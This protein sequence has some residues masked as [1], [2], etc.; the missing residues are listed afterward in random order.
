MIDII[1]YALGYSILPAVWPIYFLSSKNKKT[2]KLIFAWI[3]WLFVS[4]AGPSV[5]GKFSTHEIISFGIVFVLCIVSTI[6]YFIN[7][8]K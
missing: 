5:D 2:G 1:A 7:K 6:V 3:W 4:C 8:K